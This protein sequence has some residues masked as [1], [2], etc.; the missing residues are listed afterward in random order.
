MFLFNPYSHPSGFYWGHQALRNL[1]L[2]NSMKVSN[3]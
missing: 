2:A 3:M 1:T